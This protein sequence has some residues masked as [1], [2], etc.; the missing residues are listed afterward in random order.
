M[1][2]RTV[3]VERPRRGRRG[4]TVAEPTVDRVLGGVE[5][6]D[7]LAPLP[8]CLGFGSRQGAQDALPAMGREDR[9]PGHGG[10]SN[11]PEAGNGEV[12]VPGPEGPDDPGVL[13][14]RPG[15]PEI[16]VRPDLGCERGMVQAIKEAGTRGLQPGKELV[17]GDRSD[18][19]DHAR[20][21]PAGRRRLAMPGPGRLPPRIETT[22]RRDGSSSFQ[23]G[24]GGWGG[25]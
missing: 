17:V 6:R 23:A 21:I 18:I 2:E 25:E 16:P 19:G 4:G 9:D 7:E 20:T 11:L 1:E 24:A 14:G 3:G 10:R 15:A 8:S 13:P 12:G 22:T 5:D